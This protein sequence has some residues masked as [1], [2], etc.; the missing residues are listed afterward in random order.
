MTRAIRVALLIVLGLALYLCALAPT[1]AIA[2]PIAAVIGYAIVAHYGVRTVSGTDP[3]IVR[4]IA[5]CG[6]LCA[7]VFVPSIL[8]EYTGR[9]VDNQV[10]LAA[11]AACCSIAAG[12]AAWRSRRVVVAVYASTLSAMIGLLAFVIAVLGSYALLRGTALQ[13]RFFRTEGDYDDFARSGMTDFNTWAIADFFGGV[14]FHLLLGALIAAVLG[15]VAGA[16][17]TGYL[18]LSGHQSAR[19]DTTGT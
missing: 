12:I 13:D 3:A 5:V 6:V 1:L 19:P 17:V 10:T 15:V 11:I 2:A 8:I 16:L 7:V 9:T 4:A 18:R 14:F